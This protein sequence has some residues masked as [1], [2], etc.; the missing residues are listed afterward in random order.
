[1]MTRRAYLP[2]HLALAAALTLMLAACLTTNPLTGKS[3]S[4]EISQDAESP[5]QAA[6]EAAA[7]QPPPLT[8]AEKQLQEDE[9]R[10]YSTLMGGAFVGALAG[11]GVGVVGCHLAGYRDTRLRNC[12][13]ASTVTGGVLGGVDGYITAKREAA[14]RNELRALHATIADVRQDNDKLR[15]FISNSDRVLSEGRARLVTLRSDLARRRL[16][17][18]QA[19]EA[20]QREE[21][22]IA[23]MQKTLESAKQSRANYLA[24]SKKLGGDPKSKRDLDAEIRRMNE[25]IAQLERNVSEYN[26]V[27]SVSRA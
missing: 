26:R 9:K 12:I 24:A 10:F 3:S 20:R 17:A 4:T 23:S 6:G 15:S 27:L 21:R 11:A 18:E 1:M 25:Q 19:E 7:A 22:N 16:S 2:V 13:A 5:E 8:P 14:G